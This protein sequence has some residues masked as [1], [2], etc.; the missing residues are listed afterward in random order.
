[1]WRSYPTKLF[2]ARSV[3]AIVAGGDDNG[4]SH[5]SRSA[6]SA[7]KR[8]GAKRLG[9]IRGETQVQHA[10]VVILAVVD[11]PIDASQHVTDLAHTRI[12][13][14]PN[15]EQIGVGRDSG[16]FGATRD[17]TSRRDGGDLSAVPIDIGIS[18]ARVVDFPFVVRLCLGPWLIGGGG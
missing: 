3:L 18:I 13:E 14:Y 15:V 2:R 12:I 11:H 5:G 6:H 4:E 17:R 10:D 7:A 1:T 8:I 16:G 9:R